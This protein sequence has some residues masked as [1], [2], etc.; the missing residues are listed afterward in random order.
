MNYPQIRQHFHQLAEL[1]GQESKTS[2]EI[3]RILKNLQ[4]TDIH[5]FTDNHNLIVL[6]DSGI[7]GPTLLFRGD[8]DAVGVNETLTL[9]YASENSYASHK[10]GHDGHTT[11]LLGLAEKLASNPLKRGKILL[12]F[13]AAEENG[14]GCQQLIESGYL[15]EF[16]I[17]QVYAL[18]NIPG[19]PKH[20]IICRKNSFTCA[21]VSCEIQ[22]DGKTAHAAEPQNGISP[23]P[24]ATAITLQLINLNHTDLQS[25][26]Y[27]IITLIE[28]HIG[29]TAYGVAAGN[30]VL[31]FTLRAKSEAQLRNLIRNTEDII[32]QEVAKI[33]GLNFSIRWLEHFAASN[34]TDNAVETLQKCAR[35]CGLN[36]IEK[37]QPFTW[38]EDFGLLTQRYPGVLFGLGSGCD[39]P[40]LHHPNYDFPDEIIQTGVNLFWKIIEDSNVLN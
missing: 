7:A 36:Y 33:V 34:N 26:D 4:I 23:F 31:R 15:D 37:E 12:F 27:Q 25:N 35:K 20:S 39:C 5:K 3:C 28:S 11:I 22:L 40:P 19:F 16:H 2:Q 10:C 1:S 8:M 32:R 38:G 21:V 6:F 18:H 29:E 13:Q 14:Q 24:A 17:D 30:G 9:P